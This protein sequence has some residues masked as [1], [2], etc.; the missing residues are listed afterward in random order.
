MLMMVVMV[1]VFLETC[2]TVGHL[3]QDE[4]MLSEGM[5]GWVAVLG[6]FLLFLCWHL[7]IMVPDKFQ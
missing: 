6:M 7:N 3:N 1:V 4:F 2:V 5:T